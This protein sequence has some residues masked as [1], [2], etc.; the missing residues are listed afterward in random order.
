MAHIVFSAI[1]RKR[2]KRE[3]LALPEI[4]YRFERIGDIRQVGVSGVR[5]VIRWYMVWSEPILCFAPI[6]K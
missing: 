3:D 5:E 2:G 4:D 6:F 1:N